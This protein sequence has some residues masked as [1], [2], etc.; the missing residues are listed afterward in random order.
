MPERLETFEQLL[1]V[2]PAIRQTRFA[3]LRAL[4]EA[5]GEKNL[6]ATIERLS[7]VRSFGLDPQRRARIHPDRW[8]QL[9]REGAP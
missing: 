4:P 3:W 9:V 5:P 6:I 7:F 1:M 2:D 8:A